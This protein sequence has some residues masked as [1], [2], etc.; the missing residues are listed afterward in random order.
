MFRASIFG[1]AGTLALLAFACSSSSTPAG[2]SSGDTDGG[3]PDV[4][5]GPAAT[6]YEDGPLKG[7]TK[8][9][10]APAVAE[11]K[12]TKDPIGSASSFT[13]ERALEGYPTVSGKLVA[14]FTTEKSFIRCELAEQDA[15]V[16]VANF[17]GLARGTRPSFEDGK[18]TGKRFYDGLIWHRVIPNFVIQGGDPEGTGTGGPG[19]DLP[20]ENHVAEPLGTLAMAASSAPSGS[21]FYIVV[22]KG[23]SADYNVFGTCTTESAIAIAAV[24]RDADDKPVTAVHMQRVDIA[25]C[26]N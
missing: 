5:A 24:E 2:S 17:V 11:V 6:P 10:G 7:C 3:A 15:P 14:L 16:S 9:P 4:D 21:Q 26:P 12:A 20:E 8:D 1:L 22:G 25:R 23:P 18:W 19:Y 13:I